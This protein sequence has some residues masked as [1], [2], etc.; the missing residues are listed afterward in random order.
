MF[1][2]E[3]RYPHFINKKDELRTK[4]TLK[5]QV[6]QIILYL[7]LAGSKKQKEKHYMK[8][9]LQRYFPIIR[10]RKEILN[11]LRD[12]DE[13]WSQFESWEEEN[14][15]E[16]LDI[17]TGVKGVKVLY[18]TFFK[19]VMNPD[20][21]PERLNNFLSTILGRTVKIL[22]VLPNES[23]RIAAESSL[24][25]MDIV[26]QFEDGSIANV[27]V[28][29]IGYLFP[30]ERSAC[31]SADMLLR[32]YKRVRRELGKKFHYRDIKKVYT[33][34]LFEKSNSVFKSFSKDIYIHRFQQQ[35]DSGIELNLLQ[36][37]TFICLDI[38]GDIIQNEDRKIENRLEEWLVFLS[39]DDPDMIIKLLNQ[40]ADFQEI[41]E[42]VYT[43]CL[44]MERMM[45]M[46][47]KELAILD[48][49]TVK[50][51]IDEMEEEVVE[52]K[53]K[54]DEA[55]RKADEAESRAKQA[56]HR[57]KQAREEVD[58]LKKELEKMKNI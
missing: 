45:E 43:I 23:A 35:S 7:L 3:K 44:N 16:Y 54:A 46:F 58:N 2:V 15:E 34:V 38:F 28:Q 51:M 30:G 40:N 31:Y 29:K 12:N 50:L 5:F 19:A 33:I 49:N 9:K 10:T 32:Q 39:Q 47:S 48:R 22:K 8:N 17:C 56:E 20:T 11:E 36:E 42:E 41:Y 18:D 1:C 57:E 4:N 6:H 53:R 25:V 27:E 26:V 21:R 52:A 14:Q 37:Y 55:V 13:L 24:L